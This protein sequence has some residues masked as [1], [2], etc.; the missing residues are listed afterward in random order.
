MDD[1]KFSCFISSWNSRDSVK[2]AENIET[3]GG[4]F[5]VFNK[6]KRLLKRSLNR[7]DLLLYDIGI[8]DHIVNDRK[9]F[10]DDYVF[11][12]SQLKILKTGG[13]L[14][15]S[16]GS[17]IVVFTVLFQINPSK[18]REIVFEDILYFFNI[19]VNLFNGLKHYK[20]GGYLEKYRLYIS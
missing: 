12:R 10:R 15:I 14:V 7:L 3:K 17:G 20:A 13:G 11:N 2:S 19:D 8:I 9:W 5:T 6:S 16:K 1:N 18:F 4:Y